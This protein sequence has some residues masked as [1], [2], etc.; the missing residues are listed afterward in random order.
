MVIVVFSAVAFL[1]VGDFAVDAFDV[2]EYVIPARSVLCRRDEEG[3]EFFPS[4]C[5]LLHPLR[6]GGT[7]LGYGEFVGFREDDG[8]GDAGFSQPVNELAVY[9]LRVV[10]YVNKHERAYKLFALQDIARHHLLYLLLYGFRTLCESISGQIDKIPLFVDNEMVDEE[11][12]S[13]CG[14]GLREILMP[15]QHID[16]RRFPDVASPYEG[17]F[18][19]VVLRAHRHY[20]RT[21]YVF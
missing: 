21:D 3:R 10:A 8:E 2:V 16:E 18:G 17:I 15:A 20:G 9:L 12:L 13:G 6:C 11:C 4:V 7:S 1:S 14:R 19:L 5:H